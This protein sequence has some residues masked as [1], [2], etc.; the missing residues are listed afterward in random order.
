M[1]AVLT[2]Q[3][4]RAWLEARNL[5]GADDSVALS[6]MTLV[7]SHRIPPDSGAKAA[8]SRE[9]VALVFESEQSCL[10]WIDEWG[11]WPT[12]E[13]MVLFD[14]FRQSIGERAP[15]REKPGHVAHESDTA[16]LRSLT[17]MI[18]YFVWGAYLVGDS[19]RVIVRISHDEIVDVY[20]RE[21]H[22]IAGDTLGAVDKI[23]QAPPSV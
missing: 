22:S 1:I 15:L 14:G 17:A 4:T 11:I 6:A 20:A 3:E 9:L 13:D 16:P 18:L 7:A 2:R 21:G 19:G 8:L 12:A 5:A 10:L 23:C